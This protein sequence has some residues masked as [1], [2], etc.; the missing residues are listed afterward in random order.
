MSR[1]NVRQVSSKPTHL[2]KTSKWCFAGQYEYGRLKKPLKALI[3]I[4]WKF[5][6]T[7][8]PR[9]WNYYVQ[10]T[11]LVTC[12]KIYLASMHANLMQWL[13][14]LFWFP[15][16]ICCNEA[17]AKRQDENSIWQEPT[18]QFFLIRNWKI[19]VRFESYSLG[20]AKIVLY[21]QRLCYICKGSIYL[22]R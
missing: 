4:W 10:E 3:L 11:V 14:V 19:R 15:C 18:S 2:P 6:D 16:S 12:K 9:K 17:P 21:L 8:N 13:W 1:Q 22:Q 5:M 20:K 7:V